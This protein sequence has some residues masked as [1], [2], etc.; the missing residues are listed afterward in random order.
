MPKRSPSETSRITITLPTP[1]LQELDERL[2]HG[3]TNRGA[4]IRRLIEVALQDLEEREQKARRRVIEEREKVEQYVRGWRE[5]PQTEEEFGWFD[6][7]VSE[8]MAE[9]PWE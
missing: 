7:A 3:E 4:V 2:A 6:R 8:S 5:Q 1:L 9:E